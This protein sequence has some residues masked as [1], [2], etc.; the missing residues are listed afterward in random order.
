VVNLNYISLRDN[1]TTVDLNSIGNSIKNCSLAATQKIKNFVNSPRGKEKIENV[2]KC[3]LGV[4]IGA[5]LE[6]PIKCLTDK[7]LK[8]SGLYINY[9]KPVVPIGIKII[10]LPIVCFIC[11][12]AEELDFRGDRQERYKDKFKVFYLNRG[13]S[14]DFANTAARVTAVIF[15]SIHFGLFHIYNVIF[16]LND[17]MRVLPQIVHTTILGIFL[18]TAKELAGSL[19]VPIGMH[20]GYNINAWRRIW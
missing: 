13:T 9:G 5:G 8:V 20:M 19:D 1:W 3:A 2:V 16:F 4:G 18:G 7:I 12:V 10:L 14:E 11:P 17:P 15:S 6:Y